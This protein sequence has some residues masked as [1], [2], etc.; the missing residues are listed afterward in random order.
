MTEVQEPT[1]RYLKLAVDAPLLEP[2]TYKTREPWGIGDSVIVSLGRRK[3]QAVIL[4]AGEDSSEF[5]IKEIEALNDGRPPLPPAFLKWLEWLAEYYVHPIGQVT[6]LAFPPLANKKSNRKS[7]KPPVIK[8]RAYTEPP[9]MTAE[10]KKCVED[11]LR[12]AGFHA[13]LLFGVTGSGKTE[14]YLRLLNETLKSGKRGLVLVPEISLT[15]Q[16][17]DRFAS[18]FGEQ[19]AVLH[20]HLTDRERTNQWWS[21]VEGDK[22]ILIGARSALFCPIPDLGLIIVDEEHEPSYKQDEKLRYNARDSAIMLAKFLNIPVVLGSATPSL[23]SWSN[24]QSGKYTLHTMSS[25]V[26]DRRLPH[27]EI[28]DLRVE[29]ERQR[30]SPQPDRPYWLSDFL[31]NELVQTIERQEQTALFLNRRGIAQ[32]VLC[33]DCGYIYRCPNCAISLTLHGRSHLVCH[34]CDYAIGLTSTCESCKVGEPKPLGLGTEQIEQDVKRLFPGARVARADRDEIHSRETLEDLIENMEGHKIDI[35]VGTQMIAKGLDFPKLTL[36][37]LVL[38]DVGFN[39][40]DFRATERSFQL[41]TQVSGRAGR[42]VLDGGRVVIQ[43]YNPEHPSIAFAQR[44]D[45]LS[46]AEHEL[47]TRKELNYPP[48]GRLAAIKITAKDQHVGI[49]TADHL[50][51]RSELLRDKNQRYSSVQILG[52]SEAPLAKLRGKFRY[53]LL[54]KSTQPQVLSAFCRQLIG[55]GSWISSGTKVQ[56]DIDPLNLL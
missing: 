15:P 11:I 7:K 26:A 8:D 29:K 9:I 16:L 14:V 56:V 51:R 42:H 55:D 47:A 4:G 53:H 20:S 49:Q 52:P 19:I 41:L 28:V 38:A 12:R 46:F 23:E 2:L 6:A 22:K 36:V 50:A 40:P 45:F 35:L 10:Q 43:T 24:A 31:Y 32:T 30:E 37:G 3:A 5:S 33:Q 13:H 48:W 1:D 54:L 18:R 39:L 25:R 27:I 34:Y 44:A 21:A 17:I